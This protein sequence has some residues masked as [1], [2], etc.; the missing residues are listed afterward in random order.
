MYKKFK[1]CLLKPSRIS[2]YLDD[3][4]GKTILFFILL[5]FI[6]ILPSLVSVISVNKMPSTYSNY[7]TESF[8][9]SEKINYELEHINGKTI[10][11]KTDVNALPQYVDLGYLSEA[12]IRILMLFNTEEEFDV[13]D[14]NFSKDFANQT[15]IFLIMDTEG[16]NVTIGIIE[17]SSTNNDKVNLASNTN[18]YGLFI[19]YEKLGIKDLDFTLASTNA[20][21]F[22]SQLNDAYVDIYNSNKILI[23]I[24][25]IPVVIS[26]GI[27]SLIL[28]IL[29]VSLIFK[30]MYRRYELGYKTLCKIVFLAYTPC[31]IFNL[32]SIFYSSL[33]MYFI[34]EIL[35]VVYISIALKHAFIKKI[36]INL[37][38]M[39][40]KQNNNQGD[41]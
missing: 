3:S 7:I 24:F 28:Q 15:V 29:L 36:G 2:N 21:L 33:L 20:T 35:T 18:T 1:D 41:E 32:L 19:S 26:A 30:M 31:I 25:L 39:I 17:E 11:N 14:Y 5:L 4:K 37:N 10:L 27:I 34:G 13:N 9:N 6:Y 16:I 40:N 22:K 12:G 38:N 8:K 23:Y